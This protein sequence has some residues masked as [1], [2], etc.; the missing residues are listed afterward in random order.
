[1]P[2]IKI[3]VDIKEGTENIV[4]VS[5][6]NA[7]KLGISIGGSVEVVNPDNN[8]SAI[9]VLEISESALE[10]AGQISN[11]MGMEVKDTIVGI[12]YHAPGEVMGDAE[13]MGKAKNTGLNLF[14]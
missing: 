12:G 9:G 7:E 3:F 2:D 4:A 1:M 5:S 10:F 14:K 8:K 13:L 11:F 6:L